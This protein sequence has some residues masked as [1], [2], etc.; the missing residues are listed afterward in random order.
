MLDNNRN[1]EKKPENLVPYNKV[2]LF[3]NDRLI[4]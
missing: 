3:N 1:K 2:P 4:L